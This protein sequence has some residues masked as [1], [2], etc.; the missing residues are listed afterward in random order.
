MITYDGNKS[1]DKALHEVPR[2]CNRQDGF[3][4]YLFDL[5]V[6]LMDSCLESDLDQATRRAPLCP[7]SQG[8]NNANTI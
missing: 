4:K 1:D 7:D 6:T 5:G 2:D 8:S 3:S